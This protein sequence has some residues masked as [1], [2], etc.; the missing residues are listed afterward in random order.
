MPTFLRADRRPL[1]FAIV[2]TCFSIVRHA[3]ADVERADDEIYELADGEVLHS[4]LWLRADSA[5]FAGTAHE[6][7]SVFCK[8]LVFSGSFGGDV[9]ALATQ[10]LLFSG[11]ASNQ[12]RFAGQR[13]IRIE[14]HAKKSLVAVASSITLSAD[15]RLDGTAILVGDTVITAG[16][17]RSHLWV[18]AS[19][20]TIQGELFGDL[21]IIADDI[22]IQ[23][24]TIIHGDVVYS[25]A[26]ELVPGSKVT[27]DGEVRR[28]ELATWRLSYQDYVLFLLSLF[29]CTILIA[30]PLIR[31]C[32]HTI[33]MS[34]G[35]IREAPGR[36]AMVGIAA[37]WVAPIAAVLAMIFPMIL[38][39]GMIALAL[40]VLFVFLS[41][42]LVAL[43][44][45]DLLIRNQGP[46]SFRRVIGTISSGLV[47][48]YILA[49]IPIVSLI[50]WMVII[51]LG[52]GGLILGCLATQRPPKL[53]PA[54]SGPVKESPS[55][56]E[57]K[58][59]E[60]SP[61]PKE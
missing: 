29:V 24:G 25:S 34:V 30:I 15:A 9:H 31:L 56:S 45:G 13:Q 44:V 3:D 59:N 55:G 51:T 35:F 17:Q 27:I 46:S 58:M 5:T 19:K 4:E 20:A 21:R 8:D 6:D 28:K 50:V 43:S 39:I 1:F 54:Q 57:N 18:I 60:E 7:I 48:L 26:N 2:L 49:T 11:T 16:E 38:P 10:R 37:L 23:P 61:Q 36:S 12:L 47:L 41:Q 32:P 33:G 52:T 53:Q 42:I 22:V 14:G 40:L